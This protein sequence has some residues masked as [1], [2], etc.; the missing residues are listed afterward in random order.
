MAN[1]HP[2]FAGVTVED[3]PGWTWE[4]TENNDVAI[5]RQTTRN[6]NV[7]V[8]E[9]GWPSG[10]G[11][12]LGSVAGIDEMNQFLQSYVC[13]ANKNGTEYFWFVPFDEPWKEKFNEP[14]KEW[15]TQWGLMD[16]NR[17][18]KDGVVIP[19]CPAN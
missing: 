12:L 2:F 5:A 1:V 10:G 18:L 8:S 9:V 15:E 11:T 4:F 7:I 19:D 6:P 14:G 13:E 16:V 17:N 3:A